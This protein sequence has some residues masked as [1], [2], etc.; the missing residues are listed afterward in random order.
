[1][2]LT[3]SCYLLAT[4]FS[5]ALADDPTVSARVERKIAI[6]SAIEAIKQRVEQ[7][8]DAPTPK[9]VESLTELMLNP[10]EESKHRTT[11]TSKTECFKKLTKDLPAAFQKDVDEII[12][13]ANAGVAQKITRKDI[14]TVLGKLD[15]KVEIASMQFLNQQFATAFAKARDRAVAEQL[16]T[17]TISVKAPSFEAVNKALDQDSNWETHRQRFHDDLAGKLKLPTNLFEE[18][19]RAVEDR[20]GRVLTDVGQQARHQLDFVGQEML[21]EV[22]PKTAVNVERIQQHGQQ[23]LKGSLRQ[24][25]SRETPIYDVFAVVQKKLEAV[26]RELEQ[27]RL[28]SFVSKAAI[29]IDNDELRSAIENDPVAHREIVVSQAKLKDQLLDKVR[30]SIVEGYLET[31]AIPDGELTT[32]RKRFLDIIRTEPVAAILHKRVQ[33]DLVNRL[34]GVRKTIAEKQVQHWYSGLSNWSAPETVV[35]DRFDRGVPLKIFDAVCQLLALEKSAKINATLSKSFLVESEALVVATV[36]ERINVGL[37]TLRNQLRLLEKFEK[38]HSAELAVDY[39]ADLPK[40]KIISK[41]TDALQSE[42][43]TENRNSAYPKLF[44][45]TRDEIVKFISKEYDAIRA[46]V[47]ERRS[48]ATK[49]ASSR[50]NHT[51]PANLPSNTSRIDSSSKS[52]GSNSSGGSGQSGGGGGGGSSGRGGGAGGGED[53]QSD[54]GGGAGGRGKGLP[55]DAI[56]QYADSG[57]KTNA[58]ITKALK[59]TRQGSLPTTSSIDAADIDT[60]ASKLSELIW[61]TVQELLQMKLV[62]PEKN[63]PPTSSPKEHVVR[64]HVKVGSSQIR[65]KM[66]VVLREKLEDR[67]LVWAKQVGVT[68]SCRLEWSEGN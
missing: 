10:K 18:N 51:E 17:V 59:T 31:A 44:D 66:S 19:K 6:Q 26:S 39:A 45:R 61:P 43:R 52:D 55:P 32:I 56:L 20:I 65:H 42:W 47:A 9:Q 63:E 27:T 38:D 62:G 4:L 25:G 23:R 54:S 46:K 33:S 41:W 37:A 12:L 50:E 64:I 7:I 57:L 34:P 48:S 67:I 21:D 8:T 2:R 30:S 24:F 13:K 53:Q 35:V 68:M 28:R 40:D 5:A 14:E 11:A 16:K 29:A 15:E 22:V 49:D 3:I 36:D 1:M 58:T 60:S